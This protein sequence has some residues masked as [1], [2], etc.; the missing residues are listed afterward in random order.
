MGLLVPILPPHYT[1]LW[2]NGTPYYYA[3]DSYYAWDAEQNEYLVV[4]PP[5]GLASAHY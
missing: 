5:Q 3:N 1:T 4:A 2:C